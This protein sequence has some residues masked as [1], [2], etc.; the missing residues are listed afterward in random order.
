MLLDDAILKLLLQ[1]EVRAKTVVENS[2]TEAKDG[3]RRLILPVRADSP[4]QPNP[5]SKIGMIAEIVLRFVPEARTD[6][7]I[8]LDAPVVLQ[9]DSSIR[10]SLI[11]HGAPDGVE[12]QRIETGTATVLG[13]RVT[14]GD[15]L[16]GSLIGDKPG[17][18]RASTGRI[19]NVAPTYGWVDA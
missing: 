13:R 19:L 5:W 3:F 4:G 9:K 2:V 10:P 15:G 16:K 18:L 1:H 12:V 8:R 6:G 14:G 7:H 17:N 11:G